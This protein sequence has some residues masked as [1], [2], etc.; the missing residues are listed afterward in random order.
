MWNKEFLFST[1]IKCLSHITYSHR[2]YSWLDPHFN[3][4]LGPMGHLTRK[5]Y[6][7]FR[8]PGGKINTVLLWLVFRWCVI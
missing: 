1:N 7:Y 8:C 5:P 3:N 4:T 6:G 2:I